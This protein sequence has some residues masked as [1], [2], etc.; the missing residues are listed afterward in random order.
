MLT[1]YHKLCFSGSVPTHRITAN[2]LD[3]STRI[4]LN[5]TITGESWVSQSLV[6][7]FDFFSQ[8]INVWNKEFKFGLEA[9]VD[10]LT[11]LYG[12]EV[13]KLNEDE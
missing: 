8:I 2:R 5:R 6:A 11:K 7:T 12:V 13:D 4:Q 9:K 10:T 1:T 3:N